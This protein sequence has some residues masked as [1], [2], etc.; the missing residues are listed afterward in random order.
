MIENINTNWSQI[1]DHPYKNIIGGTESVKTNALV[2][3]KSHWPDINKI[4]LYDKDPYETKYQ[5][6]I[7]KRKC[8]ALKYC[9]NCRSFIKNWYDM[10][11]IYENMEK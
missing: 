6:S 1:P 7:K 3:M 10:D 8:L 5:L 9:N 2:N 4:Y 11:D